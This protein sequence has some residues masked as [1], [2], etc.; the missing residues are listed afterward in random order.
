MEVMQTHKG[1]VG[2]FCSP[3]V[4]ILLAAG[5][6]NAKTWRSKNV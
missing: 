3:Q 6:S 1:L 2:H 5:L 4:A